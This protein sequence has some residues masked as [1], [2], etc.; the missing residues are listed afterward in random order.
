MHC[1]FC[2]KESSASKSREHIIPESLGNTTHCLPPGVVCDPCNSYFS[3]EIEKPFL[4]SP[5][6]TLLRFRQGIPSKRGKIPPSERHS[7]ARLSGRVLERSQGAN[8]FSHCC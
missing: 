1:I 6:I 4:G 5:A 2:K 3:R 8:P 7:I